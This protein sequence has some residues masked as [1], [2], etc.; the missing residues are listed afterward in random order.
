[1]KAPRK[2]VAPRCAAGW[3]RCIRD[4]DRERAAEYLDEDYRLVL[5]QPA[6]AVVSR[7]Q[8]LA[9]LP[10]YHL[11][12]WTVVEAITDIDGEVAAILQRVHMRAT[13]L[14]SDRSGLFTGCR[15]QLRP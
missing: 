12:E 13:V 7:A 3:Q 14:G 6:R 15:T 1:M 11:H 4:R 8:W 10:D 5:V 2:V 9:T